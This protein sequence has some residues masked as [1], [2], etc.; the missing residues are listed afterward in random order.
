[1]LRGIVELA[2]DPAKVLRFVVGGTRVDVIHL[3]V[4]VVFI[5]EVVNERSRN[6][7]VS[8]NLD[9]CV[10]VLV[11]I[12]FPFLVLAQIDMDVVAVQLLVQYW[13]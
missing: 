3:K 7:P 6:E 9:I 10:A 13:L 12:L 1:M 11:V 5:V 4:L 8:W 2:R